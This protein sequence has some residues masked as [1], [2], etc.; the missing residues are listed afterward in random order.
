[1]S[2]PQKTPRHSERSEESL[3]ALFLPA[4]SHSSLPSQRIFSTLRFIFL[5]FHFVN[6]F[7][8]RREMPTIHPLAAQKLQRELLTGE[9]IYWAGMPMVSGR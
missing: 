2:R 8:Q 6:Y 5:T 7:S 9:T 4:P 3:F 1:M